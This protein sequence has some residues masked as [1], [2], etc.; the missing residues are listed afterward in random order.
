MIVV[1]G[2]AETDK[3]VKAQIISKSE[4]WLDLKSCGQCIKQTGFL[5]REIVGPSTMLAMDPLARRLD[6]LN[7]EVYGRC[8]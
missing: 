8:H 2:E 1:R 3:L 4:G 6:Q 7:P 5:D